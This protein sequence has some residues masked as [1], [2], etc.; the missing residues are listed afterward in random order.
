MFRDDDSF[1]FQ[2]VTAGLR[3]P[4]MRFRLASG[5]QVE[6]LAFHLEP[7]WAFNYESPRP[8]MEEVV[9]RLYPNQTPVMVGEWERIE[10]PAWLCIADLFSDTPAGGDNPANCSY[11][12]VCG[13]VRNADVGVRSMVCELLSQ[14]DWNTSANGDFL[15]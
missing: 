12:L 14:V 5:R 6:L 9:R 3:K 8:I 7:A 1:V 11:L 4:A 10:G 2:R 13:L 15:W